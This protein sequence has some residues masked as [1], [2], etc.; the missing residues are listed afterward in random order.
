MSD[1]PVHTTIHMS[2]S[3]ITGSITG[4]IDHRSPRER[5]LDD[6][7]STIA[8]ARAEDY[9]PPKDSFG[10][11]ARLW[12]EYLGTEIDEADV[13]I[14]M[15]LMKTSRLKTGGNKK[16]RDSWLDIAG[17]AGCGFEVSQ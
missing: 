1:D 14:M 7:K 11:I 15:V 5:L 9:G 4:S 13:A 2:G 16:H 12:T 10:S 6:A 8:T 17:Y 3:G